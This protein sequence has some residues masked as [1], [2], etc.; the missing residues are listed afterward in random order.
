MASSFA[1]INAAMNTIN[2]GKQTRMMRKMLEQQPA[3]QR[4]VTAIPGWYEDPTRQGF[5]RFWDG[6]Q[7]T[8][9][10]AERLS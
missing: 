5:L 3:Q 8:E 4:P 1:R 7:W 10:C 2:L 9:H 6:A